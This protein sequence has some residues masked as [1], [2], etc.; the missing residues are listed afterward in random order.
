[1]ELDSK[2]NA[3]KDSK[4]SW[5]GK[6]PTILFDASDKEITFEPLQ[7][8]PNQ[9]PLGQG[10]PVIQFVLSVQRVTPL[11]AMYNLDKISS[12]VSPDAAIVIIPLFIYFYVE[13]KEGY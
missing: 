9:L 5:E 13:K 4:P 10:C 6:V 8:M 1:M 11:V 12:S 3:A 7:T 2:L